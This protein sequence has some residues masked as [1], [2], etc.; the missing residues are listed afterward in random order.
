MRV[1]EL[2]AIARGQKIRRSVLFFVQMQNGQPT[3][4]QA[5][6]IHSNN[7]IAVLQHPIV[8]IDRKA[9]QPQIDK[10]LQR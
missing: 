5:N 3:V 9:L 4:T 8:E 1:K 10:L 2:M 6:Y 7:D